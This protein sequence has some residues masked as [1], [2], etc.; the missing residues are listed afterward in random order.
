[1]EKRIKKKVD[2][3]ISSFKKDII[4]KLVS[5]YG[6]EE[7]NDKG[8]AEYIYDYNRLTIEKEDFMK[9]KRCK[10]VV[11]TTER[12]LALRSNM[13]Q[14][15]RRRREGCQFCGT[16]AKG[17]PYGIF[18]D[19]QQCEVVNKVQIWLQEI[20]GIMN[21]IDENNNIY[22]MHDIM[23]N[24]PSP[25]IIGKCEIVNNDRYIFKSE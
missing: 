18:D 6:E 17:S 12:C 23:N 5:E 20:E 22:N 3:F 4:T 8:L 21:Y 25:K 19:S 9:R 16:H 13:E 24:E 10:N 14:C 7:I 1:M 2:E 11:P 15:T